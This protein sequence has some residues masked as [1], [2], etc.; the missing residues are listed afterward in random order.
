MTSASSGRVH[1]R[2]GRHG[3]ELRVDGTLASYYRPGAAAT[4]TVWDAIAAPILALEPRRRRSALVL[5]LGGGSATRLIRTLAPEAHIVGV[6]LDADV[7]AAARS[8]FDLDALGVEIVLGDALSVLR[9]ERRCFDIVIED[10]F[11]GTNRHVRKPEGFP[12]PGLELAW[13][14]VAR[15]GVLISNTIHEAPAVARALRQV[16][17]GHTLLSVGVRDYYNHI[18]AVGPDSLAARQLRARLEAQPCFRH[19][20]PRLSLRTLAQPGPRGPGSGP[21]SRRR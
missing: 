12:L 1:V 9:R 8:Y 10:V 15:G 14:R 6:E 3:R 19:A 17:P 11:V 2:E 21:Q 7:V 13:R 16:A 20:L 4:G 18:L 5:G